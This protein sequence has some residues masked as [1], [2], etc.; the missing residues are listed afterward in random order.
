M[1][2]NT[3]ILNNRE[4]KIFFTFVFLLL[5]SSLSFASEFIIPKIK[6]KTVITIVVEKGHWTKYLK[7]K[8][9]LSF[10]KMT[11][12]PVNIV[13]VSLKDM[14]K[15]QEDSLINAKG[16]YDLLSL[17]VGWAKE[18]AAKGYT[19]S[20]NELATQY[21]KSKSNWNRYLKSFYPS[22]LEILKYQNQ[23]HSI[24]Y[25]TYV[26]GNH[27]RLDLFDNKIEQES[28]KLRYKYVLEPPKTLSQLKD[29]AEFF[30][31]KKGELLKGEML[32]KDFYGVTLMSGNKP[33]INDE[34]S[35]ILWAM[36]GYWFK[37]NYLNDILLSFRLPKDYELI[38]KSAHYYLDLKKFAFP[39][40]KN[41]AFFESANALASGDVAMW[42][43]AYNNLWSISSKLNSKDP[44]QKFAISD[45]P[46][47][48]PYTGAYSF[49]V[50]YDSNN[51]EAAF[52]FLRFMTSKAGQMDYAKGGGN[53]TRVDVNLELYADS[54]LNQP[55]L[56]S[57][58]STLKAN[59][60][61]NK[62]IKKYGHFTSTA[63][64]TIY[65]L[66][67]HYTYLIS[68]KELDVEKGIIQLIKEIREAQNKYGEKAM[69]GY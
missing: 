47:G 68:S 27:Y 38:K 39:A 6:N 23:L 48:K 49:A 32:N 40:N 12:V 45:T 44:N 59:S 30:T 46:G 19:I 63:M 7:E 61:W 42:P 67:A 9:S 31:R 21:N 35:S 64:G 16:D 60:L 26:M 4:I 10:T 51:P 62:N 52:W 17:E 3:F 65:P 5:F 50:S 55:Q 14:H 58:K 36:G 15:L 25:N 2:L 66:L 69:L 24:P 56:Y 37:P 22:L 28:F 33:H 20:L 54:K 53:P 18:W 1:I 34:W 43:F 57:L 29:V 8:L 13:E 11:E 41:F